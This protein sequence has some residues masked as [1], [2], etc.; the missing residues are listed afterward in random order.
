MKSNNNELPIISI[1]MPVY[2]GE[3]YLDRSI[4]SVLKQTFYGFELIL[5]DD[6][7]TDNSLAICNK[8][9]SNDCR[10]KVFSSNENRGTFIGNLSLYENILGKYIMCI[11]QD[12]WY[13]NNAIEVA[14]NAISHNDLDIVVFGYVI[15]NNTKPKFKLSKSVLDNRTAIE[16]LMEDS[17]IK[18]YFWN[19]IYKKSVFVSGHKEWSGDPECFEDFSVMP[20]IFKAAKKVGVIADELYHYYQNPN[21]FSHSTKKNILNYYLSKSYWIRVEFLDNNYIDMIRH[22]HSVN[23]A[24]VNS[25][26]VWKS[27]LISGNIMVRQYIEEN[28]VKHK[29]LLNAAD[30]PFVK[31]I[32]IHIIIW[33][34]E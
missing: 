16:K 18:S 34:C 25:L 10:V 14:Y 19:K 28:F 6:N 12:D 4:S 9:A 21:N 27:S 3:H 32:I 15:N 5:V 13:E 1:I 11:D 2:N 29:K 22:N 20:Y 8:Y 30:I 31:R 26:G 7:S 33:L 24:F 23:R 17:E